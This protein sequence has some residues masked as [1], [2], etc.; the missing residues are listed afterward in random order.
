MTLIQCFSTQ[1]VVNKK[2]MVLENNSLHVVIKGR[3]FMSQKCWVFE[4]RVKS[5]RIFMTEVGED[6]MLNKILKQKREC[7]VHNFHA[8]Q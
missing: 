1:A 3:V 8:Q 2:N 6:A 7:K 5:G 4:I